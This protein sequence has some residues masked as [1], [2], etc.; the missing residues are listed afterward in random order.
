M[1]ILYMELE[2]QIHIDV[3]IIHGT[4]EHAH[5]MDTLYIYIYIYIAGE[6]Y[7]LQSMQSNH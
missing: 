4:R 1:Y 2:N 5:V 6:M 3:H 7:Q